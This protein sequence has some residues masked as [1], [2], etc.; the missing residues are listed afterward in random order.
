MYAFHVI[1]NRCVEP[2]K[3]GN[4]TNHLT[5][6]SQKHIGVPW[7]NLQDGTEYNM[8]FQAYDHFCKRVM[9]MIESVGEVAQCGFEGTPALKPSRI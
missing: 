1:S 5:P 3:C 2:N 9:L 7:Y 6:H 4:Q 8:L